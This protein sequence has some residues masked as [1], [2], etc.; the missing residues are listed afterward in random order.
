MLYSGQGLTEYSERRICVMHRC[1][2][3]RG[4]RIVVDMRAILTV[5]LSALMLSGCA[6][7]YERSAA[8]SCPPTAGSSRLG[9]N[10]GEARTFGSMFRYSKD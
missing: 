10:C 4:V 6:S 9:Q 8:A 3:L 2:I 7:S 5:I 1:A